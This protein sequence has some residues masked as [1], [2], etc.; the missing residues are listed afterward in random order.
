MLAKGKDPS[1]H[2]GTGFAAHQHHY[3][4]TNRAFVAERRRY[5]RAAPVAI[6]GCGVA[7]LR[8]HIQRRCDV[9]VFD[10]RFSG[11]PIDAIARVPGFDGGEKWQRDL[12]VL[13]IRKHFGGPLVQLIEKLVGDDF[14][15]RESRGFRGPT[16]I[17]PGAP[18]TPSGSL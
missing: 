6:S 15:R 5:P 1:I 7:G 8:R 16:G 18:A 17:S 14:A 11:R 4:L 2:D 9:V 10:H 13:Q 12:E 3:P